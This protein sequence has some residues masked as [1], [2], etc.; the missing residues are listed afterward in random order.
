MLK[1]YFQ[2]LKRKHNIFAWLGASPGPSRRFRRVVETIQAQLLSSHDQPM[3]QALSGET[4][5]SRLCFHQSNNMTFS[6]FGFI[7]LGMCRGIYVFFLPFYVLKYILFTNTSFPCAW[8]V[9][10]Y[11][12]IHTHIGGSKLTYYTMSYLNICKCIISF[13]L[14]LL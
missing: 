4:A 14:W 9:S 1:S 3:A 7:I 2:F 12:Q 10:W 5:Y 13:T 6:M 8:N 11:L